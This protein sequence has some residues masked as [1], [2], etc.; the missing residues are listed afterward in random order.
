MRM[1]AEDGYAVLEVGIDGPGQM[2]KHAQMLQPDCVVVTSIG[3]DHNRSLHTIEQ[4]RDEKAKM[5]RVLGPSQTAFLNGDD[6]NVLWMKSQTKAHVITFGRSPENDVIAEDVQLDWPRGMHVAVRDGATRCELRAGLIGD[7]MVYP[8]LAA[9]AVARAAG[10]TID[11]IRRSLQLLLPTPG[12]LQPVALDGS[13]W[14]LRDEF[15]SSVETIDSALDVLEAIPA[16]RKWVVIGEV[17]EPFGKQGPIYKRIGHRMGCIASYVIVLGGRKQYQGYASSFSRTGK[18]RSSIFHA[19]RN[20]FRA[21][22]I[23][24][25]HLRPGDVVLLKGRDT[26]KLERIAFLLEGHSVGCDLEVCDARFRC[27]NCSLLE[28]GYPERLRPY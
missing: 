21:T 12:C 4:T 9:F 18:P 11:E 5:V 23:L 10:R 16:Q 2:Q 7:K 24:K 8:I 22:E 19:G 15:K 14:V 27:S 1:K 3:S 26:Q 20:V 25:E 28:S 13:A 6:P 17:S